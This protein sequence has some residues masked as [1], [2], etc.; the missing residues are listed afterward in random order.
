MDENQNPSHIA[1]DPKREMFDCVISRYTRRQALEDGVLVEVTE[2]ARRAG[3]KWPL[4]M[5][6]EV[7]GLIERVPEK[8]GH[9]DI[10]GRLW[11]VLIMARRAIRMSNPG[12]QEIPFDVM[13][14][15]KD[16]SRLQLK[17]HCSPG[18]N[19]E[20][21]LTIMLPDQD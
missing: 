3:F 6:A 15:Q 21:V 11:D 8:F 2:A 20:P 10:Q 19:G 12:D 13:L 14:H 1:S 4:A 9:E 16:T 18:D 7:W 5:T 17:I